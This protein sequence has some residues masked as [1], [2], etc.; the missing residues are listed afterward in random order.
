MGMLKTCVE[1]Q[2]C[3]IHRVVTFEQKPVKEEEVKSEFQKVEKSLY[4]ISTRNKTGK[5]EFNTLLKKD[6]SPVTH[7][8][9]SGPQQDFVNYN[10]PALQDAP[11]DKQTKADLDKLLD[12]NKDVFAEDERQIGTTPL[13]EMTIDTGDH[14]PIAMK[15]YTLALKHYDW[16]RGEI[17]TLLEAGVIRNLQSSWSAP[18]V[19]QPRVMVGKALCRLQGTQ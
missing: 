7:I 6:L 19:L 16:W 18:I 2:I 1:D 14:P 12:N 11:F 5:I 13:I 15:P 9:E 10:K 3:T 8:N 17:N 4:H